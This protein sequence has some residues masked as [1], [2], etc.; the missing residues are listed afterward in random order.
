MP[1]KIPLAICAKVEVVATVLDTMMSLPISDKS[2]SA[3]RA[4][5]VCLPTAVPLCLVWVIKSL[6]MSVTT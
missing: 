4:V 6:T 3:S 5:K 1:S 2:V